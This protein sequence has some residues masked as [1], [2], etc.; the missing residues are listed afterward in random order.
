MS[1][2]GDVEAAREQY[3]HLQSLAMIL[4]LFF[5]LLFVWINTDILTFI[6]AIGSVCIA[7]GIGLKVAAGDNK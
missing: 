4:G 2:T 5:T 3:D 6:Y 7:F 1:D